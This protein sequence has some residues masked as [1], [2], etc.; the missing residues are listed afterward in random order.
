MISLTTSHNFT[1]TATTLSATDTGTCTALLKGN[2]S[3]SNDQ[4]P[5]VI[6]EF[7]F[8]VT[9]PPYG[10]WYT[11]AASQSPINGSVT[12]D[13]SA[14]IE[15]TIGTTYG[16]KITIVYYLNIRNSCSS[17]SGS[18]VSVTLPSCKK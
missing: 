10:P 2:V 7:K 5:S 11:V 14:T 18:D 9:S 3:I 13:V 6:I 17:I 15:S 8:K 4:N 16:L 12:K 1:G